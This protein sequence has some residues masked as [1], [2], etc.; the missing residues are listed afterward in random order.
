MKYYNFIIEL[1]GASHG[2]WELQQT[3]QLDVQGINESYSATHSDD[4][5]KRIYFRGCQFF[6]K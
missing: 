3:Y 2:M 4:D 1:L 5:L 6:T